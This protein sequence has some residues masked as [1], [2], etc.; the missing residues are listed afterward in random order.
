MTT[1]TPALAEHFAAIAL[2][3]VTREYPHK[4][5]HVLGSDGDAL[6]PRMLHA[7]FFGS[8]DWHS[9]V[10]GYWMLA[11][12]LRRYPELAQ[13]GE[14]IRLFDNAFTSDKVAVELGYLSRPLSAGFERTYGWAWLLKLQAELAEHRAHGWSATLAP[15]AEAFAE[16]FKTF[17]PKL[18]YPIRAGTHANTAFALTLAAD[19]AQDHDVGLMD[20]LVRRAR[21]WFGADRDGRGFEPSGDDFLSPLLMEAAC[22]QRL[23][24]AVEFRAWLAAFLPGLADGQPGFLF[25]PA[26]VSD[27][28]DGKIAHLDGLNLSRAWCLRKIASTVVKGSALDEAADAHLIQALPHV[29]GDYMGEHWLAS[30]AV[31]ALDACDRPAA[32]GVL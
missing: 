28:S 7:I 12:L 23:L 14:I 31:L 9:C 16:R 15:L 11:R 6:P 17:L 8:F 29:A 10:H 32:A 26:T 3:H 2:G 20:L 30:F 22:L 27:R 5:D 25:T 4:L 19:Y 1:L 18:T 24:P 21:D 13:G